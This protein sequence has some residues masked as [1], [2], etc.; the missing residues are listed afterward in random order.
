[1]PSNPRKPFPLK[2][3]FSLNASLHQRHKRP[4]IALIDRVISHCTSLFPHNAQHNSLLTTS[5]LVSCR[6]I[7]WTFSFAIN[8]FTHFTLTFLSS[9]LV[10]RR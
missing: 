10:I 9:P 3:L 4:P 1:M 8:C 7:I 6:N 5:F 2:V